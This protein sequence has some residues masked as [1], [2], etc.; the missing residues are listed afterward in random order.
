MLTQAQTYRGY[1][2]SVPSYELPVTL[3]I[4]RA[5]L[6]NEDL[7]SDD[8]YVRHL[9]L[10]AAAYIE[11]TYGLALLTQTIV[12]THAAFPSCAGNP[13]LLRIAPLVE[14]TSIQYLDTA[15]ATQTWSASEYTSGSFNFSPFVVPKTT[16]NFP[17]SVA[18]LPNAVTVTYRAGFGTKSS[19]VPANIRS[20]LLLLVAH[21][22]ENREDSPITL[23]QASSHLLSSFY[24]FSI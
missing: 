9:I 16:Y 6:R 2:I 20:A 21:M 11:R 18:Q 12:E 19:A 3:E 1:T 13:M 24:R 14:I 5:H 22:Y 8:E 7:N 4:V 17:T 10:G 23:P 15:G